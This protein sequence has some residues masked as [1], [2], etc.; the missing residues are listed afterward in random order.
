MSLFSSQIFEDGGQTN[1]ACWEEHKDC[2]DYCVGCCGL[3]QAEEMC[4]GCKE[5][6][7]NAPSDWCEP[8]PADYYLIIADPFNNPEGSCGEC[9]NFCDEHPDEPLCRN[10]T[11]GAGGIIGPNPASYNPLDCSAGKCPGDFNC[12]P[13]KKDISYTACYQDEDGKCWTLRT[14]VGN[15]ALLPTKNCDVTQIGCDEAGNEFGGNCLGVETWCQ[16]RERHEQFA[17]YGG[18]DRSGTGPPDSPGCDAFNHNEDQ[19]RCYADGYEECCCCPRDVNPGPGP[20]P[21]PGDYDCCDVGCPGEPLNDFL[22][23]CPPDVTHP[24]EC[25]CFPKYDS[26]GNPIQCYEVPEP[27]P[28]KMGPPCCA[29]NPDQENDHQL[30]V[31][32]SFKVGWNFGGNCA[33]G[34]GPGQKE[35]LYSEAF[36]ATDFSKLVDP[37]DNPYG[38]DGQY[39]IACG[40]YQEDRNTVRCSQVN[41]CDADSAPPL[42]S[43]SPINSPR[44]EE[45]PNCNQAD[46]QCC[47]NPCT[48]NEGNGTQ[49]ITDA[50]ECGGMNPPWCDCGSENE[51]CPKGCSLFGDSHIGYD[52]RT[53]ITL[54]CSNSDEAS[55]TEFEIDVLDSLPVPVISVGHYCFSGQPLGNEVGNCQRAECFFE[56]GQTPNLGLLSH[57][58]GSDGLEQVPGRFV[59]KV[60]YTPPNGNPQDPCLGGGADIELHFIPDDSRLHTVSWGASQIVGMAHPCAQ[61]TSGKEIFQWYDLDLATWYSNSWI[62]GPT[63][64][65]AVR[66]NCGVLP[67]DLFM[68]GPGNPI[69]D[70]FVTRIN[71]GQ[72]TS[73]NALEFLSFAQLMGGVYN[74]QQSNSPQGGTL[75][76]FYTEFATKGFTGCQVCKNTCC[77]C[78]GTTYNAEKTKWSVGTIR[79]ALR[80]SYT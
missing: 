18:G 3:W 65:R 25:Y 43:T 55:S 57:S 50:I 63:E 30:R 8:K 27:E 16:W 22:Q 49:R 48:C 4:P 68:T 51:Y 14:R 1:A 54:P 77:N 66:I 28:C 5:P 26:L 58:I 44:K 61:V 35:E 13:L 2:L 20:G 62:S 37:G 40:A 7:P 52:Q 6:P 46:S 71:Q 69:F 60:T 10:L 19:Q 17:C 39:D 73:V 74:N 29:A 36:G 53:Q 72:T 70:E 11:C 23:C 78:D 47:G 34:G 56:P 21:G 41:Q 80:F 38:A 64:A 32:F 33:C 76:S 75:G 45:I 42:P 31:D 15:Y 79:L 59:G 67:P 24:D 9:A 12:W